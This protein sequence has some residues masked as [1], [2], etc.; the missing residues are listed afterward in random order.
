MATAIQSEVRLIL[1]SEREE[2]INRAYSLAWSDWWDNNERPRLSRWPRTRANIYFEY[3]ASRL[4]YEF[5]QDSGARFIFQR[6]SFKLI[7][8]DRLVLRF[9][10]ANN[11]G[12][13]SNISTQA[14]MEFCE[15]QVDIPGL[16]GIQKVEI[17]YTLNVTGTG[18]AEIV[19]QARNGDR[20]LWK[21]NIPATGGAA[22][23]PLIQPQTPTPGADQMIVPRNTGIQDGEV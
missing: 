11:N 13:G 14:E 7:I 21:Y 20:T 5:S 23:V 10:K 8:D 3:L 15:P 4:I 16:P 19:V 22:V 9:K 17:V 6:E 1:T 12:V 18:L 2:R